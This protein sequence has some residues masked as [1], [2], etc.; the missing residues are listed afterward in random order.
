MAAAS[1]SA[2]DE[3]LSAQGSADPKDLL[4]VS[5]LRELARSSLVH[6]LISV[7]LI[8]SFQLGRSSVHFARVK[9]NGAKTLVLDPTLAGP[10]SLVTDVTLLQVR[11]VWLRHRG[12][13]CSLESM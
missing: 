9:V 10:L 13:T 7:R 1:T 11:I 2:S 12:A 6:A 3:Q 4:D 5:L 8:Y